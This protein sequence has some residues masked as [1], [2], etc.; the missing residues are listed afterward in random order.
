MAGGANLTG[1]NLTV[2]PQTSMLNIQDLGVTS[3]LSDANAFATGDRIARGANLYV[4]LFGPGLDPSQ[5]VSISGP[6]DIVISNVFGIQSTGGLP[7][8][9]F[10]VAVSPTAAL[11]GRTV[12]VRAANGDRSGFT[13]GLEVTP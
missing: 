9:Q 3:S 5:T 10:S 1:I 13:G 7:G 4:V 6:N 8:L 2:K 11:G 12:Y